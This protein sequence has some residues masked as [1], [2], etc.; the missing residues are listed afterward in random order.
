MPATTTIST[1]RRTERGDRR[2]MSQWSVAA[3]PHR[4]MREGGAVVELAGAAGV[5]VGH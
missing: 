4:V 2:V 1:S 3:R 5:G